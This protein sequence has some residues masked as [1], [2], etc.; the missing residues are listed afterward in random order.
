MEHT[1]SWAAGIHHA[2]PRS[3]PRENVFCCLCREVDHTRSQCALQCLHPQ[4]TRFPATATRRITVNVCISWNKGLCIFP[5]NCQ[6]EHECATCYLPHK[7][8][9]CPRTPIARF[10]SNAMVPPPPTHTSW[11][12]CPTTFPIQ[13]PPVIRFAAS[14][15]S[16]HKD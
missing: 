13:C 11:L 3:W 1:P 6:Y 4:T 9:D 15:R 8:K 16:K 10:T 5:G 7:A 2:G 14:V 12:T